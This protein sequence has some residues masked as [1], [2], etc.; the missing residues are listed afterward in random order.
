[1]DYVRL[2]NRNRPVLVVCCILILSF[3]LFMFYV[4][5][6]KRTDTCFRPP[7]AR[8][9]PCGSEIIYWILS[10][11][12][13]IYNYMVN[14]GVCC[15]DIEIYK[16]G[17]RVPDNLGKENNENNTGTRHSSRQ[18]ILAKDESWNNTVAEYSTQKDTLQ[19]EPIRGRRPKRARWLEE[20]DGK[21]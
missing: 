15:V 14:D 6:P 5:H 4:V 3:S 2:F 16:K 17:R 8:Q 18:W 7:S 12:M 11:T 1:M 20:V 9:R 10:T 13:S 19:R 21:V